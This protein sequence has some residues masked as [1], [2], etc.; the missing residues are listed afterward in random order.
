MEPATSPVVIVLALVAVFVPPM[1]YFMP[2]AGLL[3]KTIVISTLA[4]VLATHIIK[5][6]G[7]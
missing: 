2:Q 7:R 3:E 1:A 6:L 4:G 5:T